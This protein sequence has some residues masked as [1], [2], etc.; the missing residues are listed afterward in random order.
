MKSN[1]KKM[2]II[3]IM[4]V[5]IIMIIS[6]YFLKNIYEEK[7]KEEIWDGISEYYPNYTREQIAAIYKYYSLKDITLKDLEKIETSIKQGNEEQAKYE[8]KYGEKVKEAKEHFLTRI[9]EEITK[10]SDKY[11]NGT[12]TTSIL[13]KELYSAKYIVMSLD[14]DNEVIERVY[15]NVIIYDGDGFAETTEGKD[16]F[17]ATVLIEA[18]LNMI[19]DKLTIYLITG[20]GWSKNHSDVYYTYSQGK[21]ALLYDEIY[22]NSFVGVFEKTNVYSKMDEIDEGALEDIKSLDEDKDIVY[23]LSN[24][25]YPIIN[26]SGSKEVDDI[27][28]KIKRKYEEYDDDEFYHKKYNYHLNNEILSLVISIEDYTDFVN[29]DVYNIN[30]NTGKTVSNSELLKIK[31]ID[32]TT[33][34]NKLRECYKNKFIE[35]HKSMPG[36]ENDP[37]YV[38]GYNK[39]ISTDNCNMK[40][41]MFLDQNRYYK[42]NCYNRF[43]FVPR[44]RI[45]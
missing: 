27:N 13:P 36:I 17:K 21:A 8:K 7:R 38:E 30:T 22:E 23:T 43:R 26:I 14:T 32:E 37:L 40:Q 3:L 34:L 2:L 29:Y 24:Q 39:N 12:Y 42:C 45:L 18:E 1:K 9:Y 28:E 20:Q 33:F 11:Q 4:L 10:K 6:A 41:P 31:Q 44:C 16:E 5:L 35:I 15:S 19:T 25:S